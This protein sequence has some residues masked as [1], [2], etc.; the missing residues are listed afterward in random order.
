MSAWY[1]KT[2]SDSDIVISTRIRLARNI[3][4]F[5]FPSRM[6]KEQQREINEKIKAAINESNTPY[7]KSLKFTIDYKIVFLITFLLQLS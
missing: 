5:P 7:A 2:G 3:D 4:G 1:E 6:N